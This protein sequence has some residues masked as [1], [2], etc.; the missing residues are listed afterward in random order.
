MNKN[1]SLPPDQYDT[2]RLDISGGEQS[3]ISII[4]SK[5]A[6]R[7]LIEHYVKQ[8]II[9]KIDS[10]EDVPP[11][12]GEPPYKGLTYFTEKDADLYFGREILTDRLI[13]RLQDDRFLA[14]VGASGSGKSSVLRAG[15]IPRLRHTNWLVH[16][17]TPGPSPLQS[18]ANSLTRDDAS[19]LAASEVKKALHDDSNTLNLVSNKIVVRSETSRM[20]I[21]VDQFEELFTLCKDE[22][23]RTSFLENLL[24]VAQSSNTTAILIA[25]RADF[26][27]HCLRYEN[28]RPWMTRFQEA[29][30]AMSSQDLVRV[31]VEPARQGGW[32]FV[33]GL[34]EQF[35]DDVGQE[36]GRLPLLSHALLETWKRRRG[37]TMTL[38]GYRDAGGVE[39]AIAR[40]AERTL[41]NFTEEQIADAELVFLSLTELGEGSEDT[42]RVATL[43]ELAQKT[44]SRSS[45]DPMLQ[46]LVEARLIT[47][48]Q[49]EVEV[50]HEALIR[51]WP[52]LH[53][54]LEQNR[55]R[56]RFER[57]LMLDAQEWLRLERDTGALYRGARLVQANE[58]ME[59]NEIVPNALAL[60][61]LIASQEL[62]ARQE[63]E[64]EAQQQRE[65]EQERKLAEEQRLRAEEAE[66]AS[67]RLR[68]RRNVSLTL[69]IIGFALAI[70]A[71]LLWQQ[72]SQ[73]ANLA[74]D[75][76][77]T[78]TIALVQAESERVRADGNAATAE[79][80]KQNAEELQQVAEA[81]STRAAANL[82][83]AQENEL[84]ANTREQEAER[85]SKVALAQSLAAI[86]QPLR[87]NNHTNDALAALLGVQALYFNEAYDGS[88]EWLIDESLRSVL[89]DSYFSFLQGTHDD[90]VNTAAFSP[91]SSLLATAG[92]DR[93]VRVWKAGDIFTDEIILE[94][95]EQSIRSTAFSPDGTLL[96]SA[97]ADGKVFIW[98][99]N[100]FSAEPMILDAHDDWIWAVEFSPDGNW[101]ATGSS[102][103]I[104]KLWE[105]NDLEAE[106]VELDGHTDRVWALAFSP[107]STQLATA[108]RDQTVRIWDL[109][110]PNSATAV[111]RSH[112]AGIRSVAFSPT[113]T[114]LAS[115]GDDNSVRLWQTDS[116]ST[117]PTV[118]QG[119]Q[120][121]VQ[122]VAFHPRLQ[123]LASASADNTIRIWQLDNLETQSS[124]VFSGIA[125]GV[126][127]IAYSPDGE[128]LASA[129]VRNNVRLWR[130]G[131]PVAAPSTLTGHESRIRTLDVSPDGQWIATGS[132][133]PDNIDMSARLWHLG[134]Q[135]DESIILGTYQDFVQDVDFS[136]DGK[137]IA[138]VNTRADDDGA[139]LRIWS[140]TNLSQ[141][142]F[143]IPSHEGVSLVTTVAFSP[144]SMQVATG[145]QNGV[146]EIRQVDAITADP[147]TLRGS[148]TRI[149]EI[150]YSPDGS[151]I[152]SVSE[153][154]FM[155][156]WDFA[157]PTEPTV[158]QAHDAVA[159]VVTYS[160]DGKWLASGGDDSEI[161][162]WHANRLDENPVVLR[163]HIDFLLDLAF[164]SDSNW[165]ASGSRDTTVRLWQVNEPETPPI[166]LR[167]HDSWSIAVAFMPDDS[168]LVTAGWD[169][170][171]VRVWQ[172]WIQQLSEVACSQ[173]PRNLTWAEWRQYLP[174]ESEYMCTCTEL[175]PHP[176]VLEAKSPI[177]ENS[178]RIES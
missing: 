103:R 160:P 22:S 23:E 53:G 75:N 164:S 82:L 94:G 152:A 127:S 161:K 151:Q 44:G 63:R 135:E 1:D 50:A 24:M 62:A 38:G 60:E 25:V 12:P 146:I 93:T 65:L 169:D 106:P 87:S 105:V 2:S 71:V 158:I 144:D 131:L 67:A 55:D 40:S 119:H 41:Q 141:E 134:L 120:D 104:V 29:I 178:C 11:V 72:S 165:L 90:I 74:E 39:G 69:A 112:E 166:V 177:A 129:D 35:L 133:G 116:W 102:D 149:L 13:A 18:L 78:A 163:G 8:E 121:R 88:A 168:R 145:G 58:W 51:R 92:N 99:S 5:L 19:L 107:D 64:R 97:D 31:I 79:V 173:L 47:V 10:L 143:S 48:S 70:L 43:D 83:L 175:P 130:S 140:M 157:N 36:P 56:L 59:E 171:T 26:Y 148:D 137:W 66:K 114:F 124:F 176:S 162:L 139:R 98:N 84:T 155:H 126:T 6:G 118:L 7:D 32:R 45:L 100:D 77:A 37:A 27:E 52:R 154:G 96:A 109:A 68:T 4:D 170:L 138:A 125:S 73:N 28:L 110:N 147:M 85:Q 9:V 113:G 115:A 132:G 150:A 117:S 49:Q 16:G 20:L 46:K 156:V 89:E 122:S 80:E 34:V 15:I 86:V 76:L 108:G 21:V 17:F 111:L 33:E 95:P 174:T 123:Q 159:R 136:L 91:D 3:Q 42:R 30:G 128:W 153:D 101:L 142:A 54:W 14:V 61:F 81:E 167:G 172:P 57:Q